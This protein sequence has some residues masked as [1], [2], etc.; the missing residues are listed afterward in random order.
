MDFPDRISN[1]LFFRGEGIDG[2]YEGSNLITDDKPILEFSTPL[3]LI[4]KENEGSAGDD[5]LNYLRSAK[6]EKNYGG[7]R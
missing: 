1:L 2:Y 7:G 4:K 5:V 3:N 6:E